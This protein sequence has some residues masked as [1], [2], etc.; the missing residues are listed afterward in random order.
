MELRL[1]QINDF[2]G[3]QRI[4]HVLL[5]TKLRIAYVAVPKAACSSM[6]LYLERVYRGDPTLEVANIHTNLTVPTLDKVK[7]RELRVLEEECPFFG[8]TVVRDP[9]RR[10]ISAY[11]D[12]MRDFH[13]RRQINK[14]LGRPHDQKVGFGKF[15]AAL[16]VR[17][18]QELQR[19]GPAF[20]RIV[21]T[22]VHVF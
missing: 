15:L 20:G 3:P 14:T 13:F 17:C 12:K 6:K 19:L 1:G 8:F 10:V 21:G 9:M 5:L 4:K 11:L 2:Y 16:I 18:A 22:R 7:R